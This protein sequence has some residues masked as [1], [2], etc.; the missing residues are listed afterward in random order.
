MVSVLAIN[1]GFILMVN[2]KLTAL[3]AHT[4]GH[5]W[6]TGLMNRGN[7][8]QVAERLT[9]KAEKS[10]RMQAMLLMDL[11][12]FKDI[13]DTFGHLLGD[14]VIKTFARLAKNNMREIDV[15]GRYGGEEFCALMPNT[16]EQEALL[17]AERIR[18][19]FEDT[20]IMS[21]EGPVKCTVSIGVCDS[22]MV[23]KDFK[24]MFSAADQALYAA[25]KSGRNKVILYSSL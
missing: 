14:E 4:A 25:K 6:L 2:E 1:F 23:G 17:V 7:L 9:L 3:L 15:L 22:K 24:S 13:N 16:N 20:T 11:D 10:K 21:G 12:Y 5:D 8:E 18:C 19:F